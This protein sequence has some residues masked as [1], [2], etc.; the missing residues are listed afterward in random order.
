MRIINTKHKFRIGI[1]MFCKRWQ[2]WLTF[3]PYAAKI[4]VVSDNDYSKIVGYVYECG[5]SGVTISYYRKIK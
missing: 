5:V 4:P 3:K 2:R 1:F